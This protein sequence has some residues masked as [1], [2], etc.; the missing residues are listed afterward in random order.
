MYETRDLSAESEL[1]S[2]GKPDEW[3]NVGS[4]IVQTVDD[5]IVS[6]VVLSDENVEL[7]T[8]NMPRDDAR[9]LYAQLRL[10]VLAV[11]D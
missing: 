9:E 2:F 8:L 10:A 7:V 6:L 5:T 3:F 4:T 11:R 1:R